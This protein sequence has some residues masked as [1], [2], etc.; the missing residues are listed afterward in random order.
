M[1]A[2]RWTTHAGAEIP[3]EPRRECSDEVLREI[4]A[5]TWSSF[6]KLMPQVLLRDLSNVNCVSTEV[7]KVSGYQ[8]KAILFEDVMFRIDALPA[9]RATIVCKRNLFVDPHCIDQSSMTRTRLSIRST[10]S[11]DLVA[12]LG[13][14]QN[15]ASA[16]THFAF[17]KSAKPAEGDSG[18][19]RD[20]GQ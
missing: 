14:F 13:K 6:F 9:V 4:A 18:Q 2:A 8:R 12:F 7:K 1:G 16:R 11:G 17:R 5:K 3:P 10:G 15:V 19:G 20:H